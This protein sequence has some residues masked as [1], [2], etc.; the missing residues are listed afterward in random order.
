M[1]KKDKDSIRSEIP[2]GKS[3]RMTPGEAFLRFYLTHEGRARRVLKVEQIDLKV[4]YNKMKI[5]Q[6]NSVGRVSES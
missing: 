6:C 5:R 1:I 3:L 4:D 2:G